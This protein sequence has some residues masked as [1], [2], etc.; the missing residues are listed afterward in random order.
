MRLGI[1]SWEHAAH[2]P[3]EKALPYDFTGTGAGY[4]S[5]SDFD[6]DMAEKLAIDVEP[7]LKTKVNAQNL[8]VS[9]DFDRFRIESVTTRRVRDE[10]GMYDVDYSSGTAADG[11]IM[12]M[13]TTLTALTEELR[14]T[15]T[16]STGL[17]WVGGIYLDK[18]KEEATNG[19]QMSLPSMAMEMQTKYDIDL[20]T[21]AVFGQAILPL[22]QSFELTLGGRYQRVNKKMD[23]NLYMLPVQ[24]PFPAN[25][26]GAAPMQTFAPD[27]TWNTFLPKVALA[28][29]IRDNYTAYAS[30]SQGYMPGGFN[31]Y[32]ISGRAEDNTFEPE[33]STNYEIGIKADHNTWRWNLTAFYMDITDIHIYKAVG[34]NMLITGNADKAHS[35]GTELEI[36]WL[37][38]KGLELSAA[39]SLMQ[40]EYDDYDLGTVKLDGE[41]M[42]GVP[43]HSLRLSAAY[44][45][46]GGL[47]GRV[48][49]RNVG[50]VRYYDDNVKNMQKADAYTLANLKLGWLYK[51]WDIYAFVRNLTDEKYIHS[52][53]LNS[54]MG[55]I[56]GFGDPRTIGVG[57]SY[58]F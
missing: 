34:P 4:T 17:R 40:A 14:L 27:K 45:H 26:S 30:F 56:A 15:S 47:Y 6:R 1:N 22:G 39:A 52:F 21:Q 5:L 44:H 42:E 2:C 8:S 58:S 23:Q 28:W 36:A 49:V 48:D 19:V 33:K 24:G 41:H 57:V 38:V 7:D 35:L 54:P 16:N 13:D 10:N 9:Y 46:P 55:G 50:N 3:N 29:F 12:Y 18:E 25:A 51:N 43:S 31:V 32:A 37:P 20:T 11:L 53:K